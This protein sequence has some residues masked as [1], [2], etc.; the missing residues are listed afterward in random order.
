M[1]TDIAQL[2]KEI[3][4]LADPMP[5]HIAGGPVRD[6]FIGARIRDIDLVLPENAIS[7]ARRLADERGG[8]FVLLAEEEGVARVILGDLI[9]D[10]SQYRNGATS[11][12]HDLR[13]RDFTINAMALAPDDFLKLLGAKHGNLEKGMDTSRGKI[14]PGP[15]HSINLIDPCHGLK[16]LK[17]GLIRAI[18]RDNLASD[19]LRLLRAFRFKAELGFM[20]ETETLEYIRNLSPLIKKVAPERASYELDLIMASKQAGDVL[21]DMNA[22]G[23]LEAI[24]PEIRAM[25]GMDQPGFHHLDV[26]NHCLET[27]C[28]MDSLIGDPCRKFRMCSPLRAWIKENNRRIPALKW[29]ALLHD[30]GKPMARGEKAGRITFYNHDRFGADL[31]TGIAKRLRWTR[32][33]TSFVTKLIRMHMRPFHLL[34]DLKRGGPTRH[35]MR[36]LLNDTGLDY[37]ALFLL[38]MADSMAGCGPLKPADLDEQLAILWEKVHLFHERLLKPVRK[39]PRLLTGHDVIRL[40]GLKPGPLVGKILDMIEEAQVE[41]IIKDRTQAVAW[42]KTHFPDN[43]NIS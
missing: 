6:L 28:A 38:A 7:M 27:L 18:S 23:L 5:V 22:T 33:N 21:K 20:I 8:A 41:G 42:L 16:D 19:P 36:R 9:M 11:I 25:K 30:L 32:K 31:A 2:L 29:A 13:Q 24:L 1:H 4:R 34:N 14:L 17:A 35:A 26:L 40:L 37:P 43:G 3:E 10:F 12:D 15:A 39:R